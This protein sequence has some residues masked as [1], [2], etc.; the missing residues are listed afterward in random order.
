MASTREE[1]KSALQWDLI[2]IKSAI[3]FCLAINSTTLLFTEVYQLFAQSGL[4]QKFMA[5]LEPFILS[6]SFKK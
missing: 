1:V 4:E 2:A 3:E 5:N 6:G